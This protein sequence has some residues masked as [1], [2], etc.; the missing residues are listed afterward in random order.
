MRSILGADSCLG[1]LLEIIRDKYQKT[2]SEHISRKFKNLKYRYFPLENLLLNS[3][4][5]TSPD[6]SIP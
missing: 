2:Q 4:Q 3:E 5:K 1:V 6:T